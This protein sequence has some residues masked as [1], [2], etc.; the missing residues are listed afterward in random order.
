MHAL[1]SMAAAALILLAGC[2]E[3]QATRELDADIKAA[4]VRIEKARADQKRYGR[5][6]VVYDLIGLRIAIEE[7]TSAMLHQRRAAARWQTELG[8]TVDGQEYVP[9]S[10]ASIKS[11]EG[12]LRAA[13]TRRAEAL[14]QI[15]TADEIMKPLLEMSAGTTAI[16]MAQLEYRLAA[17]RYGF[18]AYYVP[19]TPPAEGTTPP[20]LITAPEGSSAVVQ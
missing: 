14:E 11:L 13:R 20:Q 17:S 12:Q 3:P 5:G 15:A 1:R 16:L 6:S 8:Y 10:M 4:Q 9:E 2:M 19:F 7:Q 18:P